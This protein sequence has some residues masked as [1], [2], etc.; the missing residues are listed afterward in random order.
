MPAS[1]EHSVV[2]AARASVRRAARK[3]GASSVYH[4]AAGRWFGF[5]RAKS[6]MMRS[7]CERQ[8]PCGSSRRSRR[9]ALALRAAGHVH[10]AGGVR[11]SSSELRTIGSMRDTRQLGSVRATAVGA[12]SDG[13]AAF[14]RRLQ[15]TLTGR[16]GW[17][18]RR[19]RRCAATRRSERH[20]A[21]DS[22]EQ[23]RSCDRRNVA[24][25]RQV[26]LTSSC[27]QRHSALGQRRVL[28]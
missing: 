18:C 26:R 4:V 10:R 14:R 15:A 28:A 19:G 27:G 8:S 20:R 12:R 6:G 24:V 13:M 22:G 25:E 1:R 7:G 9:R 11:H 2:R 16:T 17:S 5:E 3:E 21:G 23:R